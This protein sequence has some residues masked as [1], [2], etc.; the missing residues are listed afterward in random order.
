MARWAAFLVVSSAALL[1]Q[2]LLAAQ[3]IPPYV[4]PQHSAV[5]DK[6]LSANPGYLVAIDAD[7][8][9][10]DDIRRLRTESAGVWR[11]NPHYHPYYV[12]GDFNW[13]GVPDFA[14]AITYA[15]QPGQFK[16]LVF[17]GPFGPDHGGKAAFISS[18]FK[19][20]QGLS[21]GDPRPVPH[22]LVVG[23]FESEGAVFRPTPSGYKLEN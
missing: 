2:S 9:C 20:G 22:M 15:R 13:D 10:A 1:S 12:V 18:W 11:A 16:V 17:H 7:C 5:L 21:F 23:P 19:L 14:V 6:W 4:E 8:S 3:A